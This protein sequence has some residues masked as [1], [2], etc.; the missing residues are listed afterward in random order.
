MAVQLF[1]G[2]PLNRSKPDSVALI[3]ISDFNNKNSPSK[4]CL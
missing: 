2:L 3:E 1:V 4:I